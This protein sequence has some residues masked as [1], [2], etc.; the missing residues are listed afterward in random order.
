MNREEIKLGDRV[1]V[2]GTVAAIDGDG[3]QI[4][5]R[6]G[7]LPPVGTFYFSNPA[8]IR[9][10]R[11]ITAK[12]L[13]A[14]WARYRDLF[15]DIPHGTEKQMG[16]LLELLPGSARTTGLAGIKA[17]LTEAEAQDP[18][19]APPIKWPSDSA[20][21]RETLEKFAYMRWDEVERIKQQWGGGV[22]VTLKTDGHGTELGHVTIDDLLQT[23]A[24][25]ASTPA[26]PSR[27]SLEQF[28][29]CLL[30]ESNPNIKVSK[31]IEAI[32]RML[33]VAPAQRDAGEK[34]RDLVTGLR[35]EAASMP[36]AHGAIISRIADRLEAA[37]LAE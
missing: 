15:A 1:I 32:D 9:A 31:V 12:N 25:L 21:V 14:A 27:S 6:D 2:E 11:E 35:K 37:L 34:V 36:N 26:Q 7:G 4:T 16:A 33:A 5:I 30:T 19:G 24:A 17:G 18:G 22:T 28:K 8:G 29:A 10:D 13:A 23:R 20:A 3:W